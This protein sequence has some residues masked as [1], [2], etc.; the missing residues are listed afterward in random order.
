MKMIDRNGTYGRPAAKMTSVHI[1]PEIVKAIAD[2]KDP[3]NL[4][5]DWTMRKAS[6]NQ[7]WLVSRFWEDPDSFQIVCSV[8]RWESDLI[9]VPD[10]IFPARY[11][12][13]R[14][15]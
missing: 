2:L 7:L 5:T 14:P 13:P 8:V 10:I 15:I 12:G 4:E 9:S 11:N 6:D 3:D 1:P